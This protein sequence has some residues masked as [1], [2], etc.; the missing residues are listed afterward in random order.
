MPLKKKTVQV[1]EETSSMFL[2]VKY[3]TSERLLGLTYVASAHVHLQCFDK[4]MQNKIIP[5]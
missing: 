2:D 1:H 4:A 3:T 5:T